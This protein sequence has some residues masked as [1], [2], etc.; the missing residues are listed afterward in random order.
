ML[1]DKY[2][3]LLLAV[4]ISI[5]WAITG[6]FTKI[7]LGQISCETAVFL[8]GIIFGIFSVI[9]FLFKTDKITTELYKMT[10]LLWLLFMFIGFFGFFISYYVYYYLLKHHH[11]YKVSALVSISPLFTLLFS[12]FLL[13]E[14]ITIYSLLGVA[15]ILSGIIVIL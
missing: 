8:S 3:L 14:S 1:V 5:L 6:I 9:I 12:F 10:H 11:S 2:A 7:C 13:E 15:L 4:G